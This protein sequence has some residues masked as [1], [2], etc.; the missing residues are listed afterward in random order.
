MSTHTLESLGLSG[1]PYEGAPPVPSA[2]VTGIAVDS[3]DVAD[4]FVFVAIKGEKLDGAEFAQYAVRQGALAVVATAEGVATMR[5]DIGALPVP[6]FVVAE[7]RAVL[8]RLAAAFY[9]G[10][11]PVMA[12]VT[13]TNGKTSV[14]YFLRQIWEA[15]GHRAAAF[16]TTGITGKGFDA[17]LAMTTPEPIALHKILDDLAANGCTHGAMEA[18]SHGLA[19]YRLH[20]VRLTTAGLTNITRDHM[21]YHRDFD[22]YVGAKL[23]LFHEILAPG[24]TAVLNADEPVFALA[25]M[26]TRDRNMIAVGRDEAADL[27]LVA[28]AFHTDGQDIGLT[29]EGKRYDARLQLIGEFQAWN[30]LTA[31]GMALACGDDP[32]AIFAALPGITGAKGR[33]ELVA[34]RANGAAVYVDYAHTPDALA[35]AIK[36]LR[37]HCEGR[38]I[39]VFGAGGDRDPGKRP[40]MGKAVADYADVAIVTDDNPRSEDPATIRLAVKEGAPEADDIGD[41]TQAILTGVDALTRPGDCLL[42]AGKGHEQGQEVGDEMRPFDDGDQARTAVEVLDRESRGGQA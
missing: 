4:G 13:G 41:R 26:A 19:Q 1:L 36:A 3:R 29:W 22:D 11:P 31:A 15:L 17:P 5:R 40:M 42:I 38:L 9:P 39:V 12:A 18:S 34:R 24:G 14:T 23:R 10:Q 27:R 35:T 20:G 2:A 8:S 32:A 37:P 33:M 16:G 30:V 28:R 6:V 21:D 7:P 25:R